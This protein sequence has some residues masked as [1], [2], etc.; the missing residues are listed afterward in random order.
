MILFFKKG[1]TGTVNPIAVV[2]Y[3]RSDDQYSF[4]Q[5]LRKALTVGSE[6]T[7]SFVNGAALQVFSLSYQIHFRHSGVSLGDALK[8]A[9]EISIDNASSELASLINLQAVTG[10]ESV[11]SLENAT[12]KILDPEIEFPYCAIILKSGPGV[13]DTDIVRSF[14]IYS[15]N[16]NA[17]SRRINNTLSL[18]GGGYDSMVMRLRLAV[19]LKKTL[20]LIT[21]L[22]A[23]FASSGYKVTADLA[24]LSDVPVVERYYP[25]ATMD[26]ILSAICKDNGLFFDL[27]YTNKKIYIKN[28]AKSDA[29]DNFFPSKF[30][31]RGGRPG[32]N[33]ISSFNVKDYATVVFE[34]EIED[35]DLFDTVTVYDDSGTK[36]LFDNFRKSGVPF[37]KGTKPFWPYDFYILQYEY[38]DS[39]IKTSIRITA[40]NNWLLSN[41]KLDNFFES[42]VY[43]K[44]LGL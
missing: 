38:M 39:R 22:T 41:F 33:I 2:D 28:L 9:C 29:P 13:L 1:I 14:I 19:D 40:T 23:V 3:T 10:Q 17:D 18:R 26:N 25:P 44:G 27:D 11:L 32:A 36:N 5:I 43:S 24:I 15:S 31:F 16:F 42:A 37:F 6:V 30:C 8:T 21:Q 35:V 34:A 7:R 4:Q 20:P 12:A